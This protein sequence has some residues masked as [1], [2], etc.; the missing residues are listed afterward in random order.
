MG[1]N[2][3]TVRIGNRVVRLDSIS[4]S[5]L[6]ELIDEITGEFSLILDGAEAFRITQTAE[7]IARAETEKLMARLM[8]TK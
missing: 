4:A 2:E 5:A 7:D 3:H 8:K 6:N 1:H